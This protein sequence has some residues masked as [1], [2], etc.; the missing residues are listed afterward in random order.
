MSPE[1]V[2]RIRSIEAGI[3]RLSDVL[4]YLL[5]DPFLAKA[6]ASQ[7]L[8]QKTDHLINQMIRNNRIRA[9]QVGKKILV[10][11]SD[12]DRAVESCE[13]NNQKHIEKNNLQLLVDRAVERAQ[14][15]TK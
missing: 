1:D 2:Q 5:D 12:L 7:Y 6:A 10:R 14:G 4:P 8:G 3:V 9:F 15:K 11:K 13:V